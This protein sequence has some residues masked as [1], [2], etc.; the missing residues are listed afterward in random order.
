MKESFDNQ[1]LNQ[2]LEPKSKSPLSENCE[3]V[4][5]AD[6]TELGEHSYD[7]ESSKFELL[8]G[9]TK[10]SFSY[11]KPALSELVN[12]KNFSSRLVRAS[13]I[14]ND[15][16]LDFE[17]L[18]KKLGLVI[19]NI[20]CVD[21]LILENQD[22]K[23]DVNEF[24]YDGKIFFNINTNSEVSSC[25]NLE[26]KQIFLSEDPLTLEGIV[27]LF[28]ELG[29]YKDS[30]RI[31]SPTRPSHTGKMLIAQTF[32]ET[33]LNAKDG[34]LK[35]KVWEMG[36]QNL[37]QLERDAWAIA[38]KDLKPFVEDLNLK[39]SNLRNYLHSKCLQSYS[40]LIRRVM[41]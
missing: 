3:K 17:H 16:L 14:T 13:G 8:M 21:E 31:E 9:Q 29:H 6:Y 2:K 25:I 4:N 27:T 41:E 5:I 15:D 30:T 7:S 33:A 35:G 26:N 37:L 12:E 20:R 38:L 39:R 36:A 23:Y 34:E 10:I 1:Y 18:K 28:H 24:F 32:K 22:S 40:E 19:D 11:S